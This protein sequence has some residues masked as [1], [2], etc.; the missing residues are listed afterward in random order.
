MAKYLVI[1]ESPTKMK[2]LSKFLGKN[3]TFESSIGHI[4]DLPVKRFGITLDDSVHCDYEV[5]AQKKDVVKKLIQE[6]KK[7]DIV[8]LCPDPDREGEAI[9]WHIKALLP[10]ETSTQR[11][12][13][14]SIT[15]EQVQLAFT[16]P[17]EIDKN[18]VDAQQA[19]RALDRIVGYMVSPILAQR[20]QMGRRSPNQ[21]SLSAGR[22]QSVALIFIVDREKE[23]EV[24]KP[25]EYW[26][27]STLLTTNQGSTFKAHLYSVE[28]KRVEKQ[29]K[30]DQFGIG[31][32][33]QAQKIEQ[34]LLKAQYQID[35]IERK[36]K[37]RFPVAP[38]ITS[39]L[40]QEASRHFGFSAQRTMSTAQQL[41]EGVDLGSSGSEGLITYMRTDSVKIAAPA[42]Q[43]LRTYIKATYGESMLEPKPRYFSSS[44]S[45]QEAHEAIRPSSLSYPPEQIQRFLS[46]DQ[47]K[48]YSLIWRRFVATE[49]KA[50]IYDT[51]SVDIDADG[52]IVRATGSQIRFKGFLAVYEE[53]HDEDDEDES[54]L[55]P[56]LKEKEKLNLISVDKQQAF[57]QPPARY[58]EASLVKALEQS[59]IGRPSTYAA[60]MN[61]IQS[62]EYT[63]K[64]KG[65]LKPTTLGCVTTELLK[66]NFSDILNAQFTAQMEDNLE[67][68]ACGQ[69]DWQTVV[70]DFWKEF[71]PKLDNAKAHAHVPKIDT[72]KPCPKC[73]KHL[74]KVW[75]GKGYFYGCSS[76]PECDYRASNEQLDFDPQ[77][78]NPDFNWNQSCPKCSSEMKVRFG[79]YGAFLGCSK[80]PECRGLINAPKA[81]EQSLGAT[82]TQCPAIGCDGSLVARKSRFGKNFYSCS[83]YPSCDVIG[84]EIDTVLE[85]FS[86]HPKTAYESKAKARIAKPKAGVKKTSTSTKKTKK[87]TVIKEKKPTNSKGQQLSEELKLLVKVDQAS[88]P[89][90]TRLIWDYI[91][92]HQLQDPK[93]KR[94]ILCDNLMQKVFQEPRIHMTQIAGK[95]GVHLS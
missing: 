26:N 19:R 60:I 6:A 25:H 50:A 77:D 36:E 14:N 52:C 93:D 70:L 20:V 57:T 69:K 68:V 87:D 5:L 37:R 58:S 10:K 73:G 66:T 39:T 40:Q 51:V 63:V 47:F 88:R 62:R 43:A 8:Y 89:E 91:K 11:V 13:F 76:Y 46:P 78:Y 44:K 85:K 53:K 81:G 9:A 95:L 75:A 28:G 1:V 64:E 79:P 2:T 29:P 80:Y 55:L 24:F 54:R 86:D 18:L 31:N 56:D 92:S 41:Y 48:I 72:D 23:I 61:K 90:L 12:T 27:L 33:E 38:F 42:Q 45:A 32:L 17:R 30:S 4:R 94:Y 34:H 82:Q 49:M 83:T 74:Q 3:Y 16:S 15:S 21:G 22:V 84:N 71:S 35:S 67:Q 65:K 59:G 7:A